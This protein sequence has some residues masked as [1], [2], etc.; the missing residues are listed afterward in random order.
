MFY[1]YY[2]QTTTSLCV[3]WADGF[4]LQINKLYCIYVI[5]YNKVFKNIVQVFDLD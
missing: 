1:T 4:E 2:V 5:V 3:F